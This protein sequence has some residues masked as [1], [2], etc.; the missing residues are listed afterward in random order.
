MS[1]TY[2]Q[3]LPTDKDYV[4]YRIGDTDVD[5]EENALR[6]NE[7]ILAVLAAQASREAA[8]ALIAKALAVEYAQ[9]PGRVTLPSSL[10]VSWEERVGQWN[11][12]AA[13]MDALVAQATSGA[14]RVAP[15]GPVAVR[16]VW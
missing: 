15:S 12:L 9:E 3:L 16:V 2:N 5:P 13:E 4:R 6:T 1:A 8:I 7:H 10:S 11:K 14:V